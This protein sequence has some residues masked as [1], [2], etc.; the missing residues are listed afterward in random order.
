MGVVYRAYDEVLQREV[1]LKV[2]KKGAGLGPTASQ[3]LLQEARASSALAHPNICTIHEVGET[4]GELYIV[5]ELVD[6]KSLRAMSADGGLSVESV[7]RYGVQIASALARAHDKGIVHRD[8]KAANIVITSDGLVKVLDF[9]LAL[10]VGGGAFDG[11]TLETLQESGSAVSGTLQYIAPE[12]L[13]GEGAD[14]RGA[15]HLKDAPASRSVRPFCANL[16]NRSAL[17]CRPV[18]GPLSNVA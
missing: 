6:G 11:S 17:P 8:L 13:R 4:D 2:V 3:N 9:G 5:M 1:A 15:C 16:P 7:L 12:V 14:Y 18:C 10:R